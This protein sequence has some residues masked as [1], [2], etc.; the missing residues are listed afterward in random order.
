MSA[1]TAPKAVLNLVRCSKPVVQPRVVACAEEEIKGKA[2]D[3]ALERFSYLIKLVRTA[4]SVSNILFVRSLG[5]L[6]K[7]FGRLLCA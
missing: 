3:I 4:R 2:S 7:N 1:L 6:K 5:L